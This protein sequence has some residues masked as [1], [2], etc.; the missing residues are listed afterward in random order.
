MLEVTIKIKDVSMELLE[1]TKQLEHLGSSFFQGALGVLQSHTKY[2][3][4]ENYVSFAI[5][6]KIREDRPEIGGE[7]T[8]GLQ[9]F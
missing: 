5:K 9:E 7:A 4:P 8:Q 6:S 1:V 3:E 2:Y